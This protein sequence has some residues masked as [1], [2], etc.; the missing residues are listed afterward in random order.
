M[1]HDGEEGQSTQDQDAAD[2]LP[3]PSD[4]E[5]DDH[6]QHGDGQKVHVQGL[7]DRIRHA[8]AQSAGDDQ[9]EDSRPARE[10]GELRP[11]PQRCGGQVRPVRAVQIIDEPVIEIIDGTVESMGGAGTERA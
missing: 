3:L 10:K 7:V 8:L 5:A 6:R 1:V 9:G 4:G 11:R 2:A